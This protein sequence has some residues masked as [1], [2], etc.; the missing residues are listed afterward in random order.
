MEKELIKALEEKIE[1]N[2]RIEENLKDQIKILQ[3]MVNIEKAYSGKLLEIFG[4][5]K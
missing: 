3:D 4:Q 2:K 1:L 5:L